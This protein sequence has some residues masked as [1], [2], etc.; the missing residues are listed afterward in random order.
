MTDANGWLPPN[1]TPG[2]YGRATAAEIKPTSSLAWWQVCAPDGSN[3]SLDP[4]I[5]TVTE[6][7]D[8]TITVTPS[9][10]FSK[11]RAGAYHGF[12]TRGIWS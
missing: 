12:L 3:G 7:E 10:D 8:G 5:H 1:F 9:L 4:E 2:D 11:R 6:H